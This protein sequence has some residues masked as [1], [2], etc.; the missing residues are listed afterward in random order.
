M[1]AADEQPGQ[2]KPEF[3]LLLTLATMEP[4]P[5]ADYE[6]RR[7]FYAAKEVIRLQLAAHRAATDPRIALEAQ[8][9]S[10]LPDQF[11]GT[12]ISEI[13]GESGRI[14]NQEQIAEILGS[15][16]DFSPAESH[17]L[18]KAMAKSDEATVEK[19]YPRFR[20]L[21]APARFA[22]Q[23]SQWLWNELRDAAPRVPSLSHETALTTHGP[24]FADA[25]NTELDHRENEELEF[26][27]QY[28][29]R[30]VFDSTGE[31]YDWYPTASLEEA[32]LV[33]ADGT[34]DEQDAGS[35]GKLVYSVWKRRVA[36]GPR[37]PPR[38]HRN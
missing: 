37:L 1:A 14:Q 21:I 11:R 8:A 32:Q 3:P 2:A 34:E 23:S 24:A 6:F 33:V 38:W 28:G 18:R 7:G 26:S 12:E 22:N 36:H 17:E 4:D 15:F 30:A 25:E 16:L 27:V 20:V 29:W 5:R 35:E 13:L 10:G 19:F 9:T 31:E